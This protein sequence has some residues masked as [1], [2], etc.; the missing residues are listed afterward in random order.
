MSP[1]NCDSVRTHKTLRN[2]ETW[3]YNVSG[4]AHT[5]QGAPMVWLQVKVMQP[6]SY[7]LQKLFQ[8]LKSQFDVLYLYVFV[9]T[10]FASLILYLYVF[11]ATLFASLILY[12]YVFVAPLS[13]F[14]FVLL[15]L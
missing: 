5:A 7:F 12:P 6:E 15:A 2:M 9:A 11:V 4:N 10:L 13:A 14:W 1:I 8:T 3:Q